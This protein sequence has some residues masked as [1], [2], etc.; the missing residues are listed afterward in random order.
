[1][2]IKKDECDIK[3]HLLEQIKFL[4]NSIILFDKGD[5]EECK[6]IA[7][8]I[9]VLVHDSKNSI[10]LLKQLKKK[11]ISFYDNASSYLP[12][13]LFPT[14]RLVALASTK[15]GEATYIPNKDFRGNSTIKVPFDSWWNDIVIDDSHGNLLKRKDLILSISNQDGG[16][17]V[18]PELNIPY[19][20][21]AK[22]KT[23]EKGIIIGNGRGFRMSL[24]QASVRQIADELIRTLMD[25]F[26]DMF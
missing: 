9:R 24:I 15:E 16:A 11:D 20:S 13:N 21:I 22:L 6:R 25:E 14:A 10:S 7:V 8:S 12:G 17:H 5:Y 26:S 2:K 19:G 3:A 23:Q 1:M 4:K 18:D